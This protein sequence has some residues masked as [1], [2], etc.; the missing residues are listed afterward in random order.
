MIS[1]VV[2]D[3]IIDA[4]AH[5]GSFSLLAHSLFPTARLIAFEPD[6]DNFALLAENV[7]LNTATIDTRNCALGSKPGQ[8]TI[9]GPSS[10]GR[11]LGGVGHPV[12]VRTITSE[13][14]V[15]MV[16]RLLL[17]IDVEGAE[18][19]V[20]S[21]CI[22][23]LPRSSIIFIETHR[24]V[25]DVSRLRELAQRFGFRYEHCL[26]KGPCH[27]SVLSRGAYSLV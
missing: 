2:P 5:I 11:Q 3:V 14:A 8:S 12:E 13:V 1:Q 23:K 19:E 4:G 20:L 9:G 27:E 10:M 17:K 16:D 15:D 22:D 7:S 26:S 6:I 24:G 25:S 21:N 18:W